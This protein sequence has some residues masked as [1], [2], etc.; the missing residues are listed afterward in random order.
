MITPVCT[1][2]SQWRWSQFM[3]VVPLIVLVFIIY[4]GLLIVLLLFMFTHS[5]G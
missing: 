4:I 3:Y 1:I 2:I 5:P